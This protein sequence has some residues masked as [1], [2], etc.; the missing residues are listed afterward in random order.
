MYAQSSVQKNKREFIQPSQQRP[1]L[2]LPEIFDEAIQIKDIKEIHDR[3]IVATASFYQ[4]GIL[5]KDRI[6]SESGEVEIL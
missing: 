1:L 6:M 5:T 3:I 2:P 4:V